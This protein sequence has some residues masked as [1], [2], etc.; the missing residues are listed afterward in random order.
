VI[1]H[2]QYYLLVRYEVQVLEIEA[3][4]RILIMVERVRSKKVE[5][6]E[7]VKPESEE[8]DEA[9]GL[10]I[11]VGPDWRMIWDGRQFQIQERKVNQ[12]KGKN[13][14]KEYWMNRAYITSL[15]NAISW[16][17]TRRIYMIKG[18]YDID[19]LEVLNTRLDEIR[20]QCLAAVKAGLNALQKTGS[21]PKVE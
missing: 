21:V 11:V 17:S 7:I 9:D 13:A 12:T 5:P 15:A 1:S 19:G 3:L 4:F 14:G 20:D 2:H 6:V 8:A 18:T 16:L 10:M